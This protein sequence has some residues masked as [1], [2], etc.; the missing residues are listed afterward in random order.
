M[1]L[2]IASPQDRQLDLW[3][4]E[5]QRTE[6][7]PALP[8]KAAWQAVFASPKAGHLYNFTTLSFDVTLTGFA[9]PRDAVLYFGLDHPEV[10]TR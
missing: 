8:D 9:V 2:P 6:A 5:N 1:V 3:K 4:R 10:R 7:P